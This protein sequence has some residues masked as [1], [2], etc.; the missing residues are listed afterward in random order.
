MLSV[1]TSPGSVDQAV[2]AAQERY[3][4]D[5]SAVV[6]ATD[7]LPAE[8]RLGIYA[9]AYLG[10]LLECLGAEFPVLKA[11]AGE[12]T[13]ALFAKAYVWAN[14][15]GSSSL[16]DLGAGF[17]DFLDDTRPGRG[18]PPGS[19]D[20]VP[21][22]LARLE[23]A[24][25]ESAHAPGVEA[26]GAFPAGPFG[27]LASADVAVRTPASSRLLRLD[28]D[29]AGTLAA[30]RRGDRPDAPPA[31]DTCYGVARSHYRVRTHVLAPWQHA[32][33]GSCGPRPAL[34][35]TVVAG[36]ARTCGMDRSELWSGLLAWLPLAVEAGM[37][38]LV[39]AT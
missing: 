32:F 28:F 16:S 1:C 23:R 24:C 20:A 22:A 25:F 30:A 13:F 11:L 3:G 9:R 19:P 7:A 36:T 35:G 37:A 10:R 33:L 12:Q 4:I 39:A 17:A 31:R 34:L 2:R 29:L 8:E 18:G 26:E 21:A 38:T 14:P 6:K 5:A 15:P 27:L